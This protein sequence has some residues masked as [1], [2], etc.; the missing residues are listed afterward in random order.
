MRTGARAEQSS[1]EVTVSRRSCEEEHVR[2]GVCAHGKWDRGAAAKCHRKRSRLEMLIR[3]N[4][5][6]YNEV[7]PKQQWTS[8]KLLL[9]PGNPTL[10]SLRYSSVGVP[11]SEVR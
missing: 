7:I 5:N 1:G 9:Q 8:P 11:A 10:A 2:D 3:M 4:I 6:T